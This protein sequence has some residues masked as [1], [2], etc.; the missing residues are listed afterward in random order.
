MVFIESKIEEQPDVS[1]EELAGKVSTRFGLQVH[2]RS[3]GRALG[4]REKKTP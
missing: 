2:P 1:L 4:R 3:I